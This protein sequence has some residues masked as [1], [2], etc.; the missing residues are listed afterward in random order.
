MPGMSLEKL[1]WR[2]DETP[3]PERAGRGR[4]EVPTGWWYSGLFEVGFGDDEVS[5]LSDHTSNTCLLLS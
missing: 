5:S 3:G 1:T 2:M 4:Y